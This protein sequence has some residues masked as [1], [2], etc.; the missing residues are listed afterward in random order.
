MVATPCFNMRNRL[1]L[2]VG[3]EVC[4]RGCENFQ[5]LNLRLDDG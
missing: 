1:F 4:D 3:H 2:H 5:R